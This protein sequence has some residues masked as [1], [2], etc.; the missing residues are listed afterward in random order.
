MEELSIT[1]QLMY[2]TTRVECVDRNGRS[3]LAT[4]F[5]ANCI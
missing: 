5:F 2:T 4:A 3:S 1:E